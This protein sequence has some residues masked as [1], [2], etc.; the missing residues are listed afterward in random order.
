MSVVNAPDLDSPG[1]VEL[2][3]VVAD[4][5][6]REVRPI[7][8]KYE[9]AQRFPLQLLARMGEL[10]YFGPLF[11]PDVGGTGLGK[12][13]QCIIVEELARG[14]GGISTTCLVQVLALYPVFAHGTPAAKERYLI[15]GI[16]GKRAAALAI[17][18]PDHGSDVAGIETTAVRDGDG[19]RL[20]GSK[21]FITNAPFADFFVV[22][23]K[24]NPSE[25]YD[26][27][28]LFVVERETPGLEVG[29]HLQKLGWFTS[30]TA[31]VYLEDAWVPEENLIGELNRGFYYIMEDFNTERLLLA[32]QAVGLAEEALAVA[33]EYAKQRRQ[34]GQVIAEFQAVRHTLAR[35]ATE[36]EA[37]R[38]LLLYAARLA[39]R[40]R[41]ARKEASMAKLL[42]GEMVNRVA[43]DAIQIL[44]GAGYLRDYPLERIYR[45]A[46]VLTIGGGTT[47]IQLNII[48][49]QVLS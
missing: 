28:S 31:P 38:Q 49:K 27:I 8:E 32:A 19:Y 47:E 22:A 11:P 24:T 43:Y 18:E 13:G 12:L 34:F 44:G 33:L 36:I 20:S 4:F 10:G 16:Q 37:G 30:E 7:I 1:L 5:V 41:E 14:S 15:P 17:T 46:R 26:G 25:R 42:C 40:G 6:K 29:A 39:D 3:E 23:A 45:D 48:A 9:A 35:M 21:M 2:R